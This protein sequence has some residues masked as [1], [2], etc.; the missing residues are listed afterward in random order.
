MDRDVTEIAYVTLHRGAGDPVASFVFNPADGPALLLDH[1]RRIA[2]PDDR[3][4]VRYVGHGESVKRTTANLWPFGLDLATEM[5]S[6]ATPDLLA[7]HDHAT[8]WF[9]RTP[10]GRVAVFKHVGPPAWPIPKVRV[11][12]IRTN[13]GA[14][15]IAVAAGWRFTLITAAWLAKR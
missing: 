10:L 14:L 12:P 2:E 4:T 15:G 7:G 5:I 6:P 3:V 11:D 13:S 8:E 1:L 9:R